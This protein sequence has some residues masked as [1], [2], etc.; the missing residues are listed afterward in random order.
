MPSFTP[1]DV[2]ASHSAFRETRHV[3][4]VIPEALDLAVDPADLVN[5][6]DRLG[7]GSFSSS[8]VIRQAPVNVL[9]GV[10]FLYSHGGVRVEMPADAQQIEA[11]AKAAAHVLKPI[12]DHLRAWAEV[13]DDV[14]TTPSVSLIAGR[15]RGKASDTNRHF[16]YRGRFPGVS[17]KMYFLGDPEFS[18]VYY[19]G[20]YRSPSQLTQFFRVLGGVDPS[21]PKPLFERRDAEQHV[22]PAGVVCVEP[23]NAYHSGPTDKAA[24]GTERGILSVNYNV[25]RLAVASSEAQ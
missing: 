10:K 19:P 23:W 3:D 8:G 11:E 5:L 1:A 22:M 6:A 20:A 24:R 9:A 13:P 4:S 25:A 18:S 14:V 15:F 12:D 7:N 16:D 17:Y 21:Y 2:L